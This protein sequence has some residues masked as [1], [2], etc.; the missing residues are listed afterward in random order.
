[1]TAIGKIAS[2]HTDALAESGVLRRFQNLVGQ[3]LSMPFEL[4]PETGMCR[5][6]KAAALEQ[7]MNVAI[8]HLGRVQSCT[9]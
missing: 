9:R 2:C 3:T 8:Q 5:S 7:I 1:M 6:R 4:Q